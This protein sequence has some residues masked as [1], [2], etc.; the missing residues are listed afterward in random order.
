LKY[1]SSIVLGLNDALVELTGALAGLT[2]ALS[3]SKTVALAGLITGVAAA[4]SMAS[5]E[6]LATK[7]DASN[8][9]A[10]ISSLYTGG[11]YLIAVMLLITPYLIGLNSY[12]ALA[13][14]IANVIIIIFVFNFYISVAKDLNFKKRFLEMVSISLG[15]A[16]FS[17]LF[18]FVI[19][20]WLGV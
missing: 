8:K 10:F 5:S 13:I 15:V 1:I 14:M 11:A 6:Y 2:F 18:S 17:F 4:F 20:A 3:N 12:V 9:E 19:T 7:Q 16:L